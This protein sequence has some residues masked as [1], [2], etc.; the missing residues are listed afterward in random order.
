MLYIAA[1]NRVIGVVTA[2]ERKEEKQKQLVQRPT[3]YL[4]KV[5]MKSKKRY[6]HYQKLAYSVFFAARKLKHYF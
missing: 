3:Y 5:L 1:T 6:L 4:S 2:V